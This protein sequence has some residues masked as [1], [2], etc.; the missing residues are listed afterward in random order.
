MDEI[1]KLKAENIE[2]KKAN[3]AKAEFI[4]ISAHQLRTSLSAIKWILRMFLDKEVGV[5]S[6]EQEGFINKAYQ[7]NQRMIEL[8]NDMLI[9]SHAEDSTIP[10]NFE[11]IDIMKLAEDTI[12]EFYG[13]A[14]TKGIEL[15]FLKPEVDLPLVNCNQGMIRVVMQNLIENAIKYSNPHGKIFISLKKD[16][17]N[18]EF[19]VHDMG[20]G[21]EDKDQPNIFQKFYRAPNAEKKNSD[22]SG[23]GLFTV[24]KIIDRHKGKIWFENNQ[25]GGTTFFVLLPIS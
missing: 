16:E 21:I 13:E 7:S 8:V 12:F 22:G 24:K 18:V 14:H 3:E 19:L 6:S 4:S 20:I 5:L 10:F 15:I 23:L 25:N 2:L 17:N 1:E 11:K 9:L